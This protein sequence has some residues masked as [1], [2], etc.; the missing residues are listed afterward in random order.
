VPQVTGVMHRWRF[1]TAQAETSALAAS[2]RALIDQGLSPSDI[3]ILLSNQRE[4][5]P[6]LRTALTDANVD[7]VPPR[8]ESF[9]DTESGRLILAILRIICD[10]EDYVALRSVLGLRN[11]VGVGTCSAVAQLVINNALNYR[12]IFY[13]PLPANVFRGRTLTA[14][15]NARTICAQIAGWQKADS[16]NQRAAE[17]T[18]ILALS[19]S[20][21]EV[22]AWNGYVANLPP[23]ISLEE[24]RDWMWADNDEQ[25]S[26]VLAAVYQRLN[27]PIPQT[28]LIPPRVRIMSMHGAKGL[29]AR[30]VFIPGLEDDLFPG[31]WR[32]AYPG[33]ILEAAR[34]LYVSVTRARAACVLSYSGRRTIQGRSLRMPASRFTTALGGPF[35][36]RAVGLTQLEAQT[37]TNQIGQL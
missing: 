31:P 15:T 25:Q 8:A 23:N 34:L 26:T 3:L 28:A 4:L 1:S 7:F 35:L 27:Q 6:P 29:S 18:Q 37:I 30:V 13:N 36:A 19:Y 16:M 21:V 14:L 2:C 17:M 10:G 12:D 32:Q 22:N 24:L 11:G 33:L 20:A 9:R 5:L